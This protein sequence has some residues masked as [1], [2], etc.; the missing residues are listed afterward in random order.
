MASSSE[1][2][3]HKTVAEIIDT[4]HEL[5]TNFEETQSPITDDNSF[6]SRLLIKIEYIFQLD[7]QAKHSILGTKKGYWD[8]FYKC[9]A[10][11]R[12][13]NDGIRF[14]KAISE[15]QTSEGRGRAFIRFCLMHH[16]L[17]DSFQQFELIYR[18]WFGESSPL[19]CESQFSRLITSLYELNEIDFE[20]NPLGCE[21]DVGWPAYAR[22]SHDPFSWR[23]PSRAMSV[24]S[25]CSAVST[26]VERDS[27]CKDHFKIN[28]DDSV[29]VE[30]DDQTAVQTLTDQN[31]ALHQRFEEKES[32]WLKEKTKLETELTETRKIVEKIKAAE[33]KPTE[34]DKLNQLQT[35]KQIKL[36]EKGLTD[37]YKNAQA[38]L[39]SFQTKV[40]TVEG[41]IQ[42]FDKTNPVLSDPKVNSEQLVPIPAPAVKEFLEDVSLIHF[43]AQDLILT[44]KGF[45]EKMSNLIKA[46]SELQQMHGVVDNEPI[47]ENENAKRMEEQICALKD[48]LKASK[49]ITEIKDLEITKLRTEVQE[50]KLRNE[51]TET[52]VRGAEDDGKLRKQLVDL[53]AKVKHLQEEKLV[54]GKKVSNIES[55]KD[56]LEK[57]AYEMMNKLKESEGQVRQMNDKL[58]NVLHLV[59][60]QGDQNSRLQEQLVSTKKENSLLVTQ[61]KTLNELLQELDK[62]EIEIESQVEPQEV[63]N[64]NEERAT[65][66]ASADSSKPDD[67]HQPIVKKVA[68]TLSRLHSL[69]DERD[70]LQRQLKITK[71]MTADLTSKVTEQ[72]Q[73]LAKVTSE[74]TETQEFIDKLRSACSKLQTSDAI[75]RH[76]LREKRH[77]LNK[78]KGQ[79]ES[80]RNQWKQVQQKNSEN[81]TEWRS[82]KDEFE[83]RK[84]KSAE[85]A[86][87]SSEKP[88]PSSP[89]EIEG[90]DGGLSLSNPDLLAGINMSPEESN[91][92]SEEEDARD[93]RLKFLEDQCR[94]LYEKLL[95]SAKYG[96]ALDMR[97]SSLHEHFGSGDTENSAMSTPDEQENNDEASGEADMSDELVHETESM[98]V[99]RVVVNEVLGDVSEQVVND[100]EADGEVEVGFDECLDKKSVTFEIDTPANSSP[101]KPSPFDAVHA[102]PKRIE[103]L[104]KEK[105]DLQKKFKKFRGEKITWE[106]KETNYKA[107]I[108]LIELERDDLMKQLA[109]KNE[110]GSDLKSEDDK[111]LNAKEGLKSKIIEIE[112][113]LDERT[114]KMAELREQ[115]DLT[116]KSCEQEITALQFQLNTETLKHQQALKECNEQEERMKEMQE[117][118]KKQDVVLHH[119]EEK[120]KM[121][122]DERETEQAEQWR[123]LSELKQALLSKDEDGAKTSIVLLEE[124]HARSEKFRT[125]VEDLNSTVSQ[126]ELHVSQLEAD[127]EQMKQIIVKLTKE[128]EELWKEN[129]ESKAQ[130]SIQMVNSADIT[131]CTLCKVDFG[132]GVLLRKHHCRLC[133][134]IFCYH[135]ANHWLL[136]PNSKESVRACNECFAKNNSLYEIKPSILSDDVQDRS[137]DEASGSVSSSVTDLPAASNEV[138]QKSDDFHVVTD[139]ELTESMKSSSSSLSL[140]DNQ[141][142]LILNEVWTEDDIRNSSAPTKTL[143]IGPRKKLAI[144][145]YIEKVGEG[146][147]KWSF[148]SKPNSIGFSVVFHS[149]MED[150]FSTTASEVLLSET[151][152]NSH[153][154]EVAGQLVP[155]RSGCYTLVFDNTFSKFYPKQVTLFV[156]YDTVST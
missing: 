52:E 99:G 47:K 37:S 114:E 151:R 153:K 67:V 32:E 85:E 134:Q 45:L 147:L 118:I 98:T 60:V 13:L 121:I 140:S 55:G 41:K 127:N 72:E 61:M 111:F 6:L 81:E 122:Q 54:I 150:I 12:N 70:E 66:G 88:Q 57:R 155:R 149:S 128:K 93:R 80:S 33:K 96:A 28:C 117:C 120:L 38:L 48:A 42:E 113:Q 116:K 46:T 139:Q 131:Q 15:I 123:Q 106:A 36:M 11:K 26:S 65:D 108:E 68:R 103:K 79:L 126:L 148:T 20:L 84:L 76:E 105:E 75:L 21:L 50:I 141:E 73:Q 4:V 138:A 58:R 5:K 145:V 19:R 86:S 83:N 7:L 25:F 2:Q 156:A 104:R 14:V 132:Y 71:E 92:L 97:L 129:F 130:V 135:C 49:E 95:K 82:L 142:N 115:M 35:E 77:L 30:E 102:L 62:K 51:I 87:T 137:T 119:T 136:T 10:G 22:K 125:E 110:N 27:F 78:L 59:D 16:C 34:A 100:A 90:A 44:Q 112:K 63:A 56:E 53:L 31:A 17:A 9:L 94:M 107:Q 29:D 43:S 101:E 152:V 23:V 1:P 39:N 3:L 144:P 109:A 89:K 40:T 143:R 64:K 18:A 133:G 69:I 24:S 146:I 154:H 124:E 8:Y 91:P 74:L